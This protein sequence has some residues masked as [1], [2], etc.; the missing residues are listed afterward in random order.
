MAKQFELEHFGPV[1]IS[2]V[3]ENLDAVFLAEHKIK[4]SSEKRLL[5]MGYERIKEKVKAIR[6]AYRKAVTEGRRSGRGKLVY[7]NWDKLKTL[8]GGSPAVTTLTNSISS[9]ESYSQ[10]SEGVAKKEAEPEETLPNDFNA[11]TSSISSGTIATPEERKC[12]KFKE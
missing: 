7:D 10:D 3:G 9:F 6:Q 4:V 2:H 1:A 8:W 12:Q 5:K 11:N